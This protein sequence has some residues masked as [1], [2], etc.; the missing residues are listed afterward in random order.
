[1]STESDNKELSKL[2]KEKLAQ[3]LEVRKAGQGIKKIQAQSGQ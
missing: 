2:V 3:E 1:M